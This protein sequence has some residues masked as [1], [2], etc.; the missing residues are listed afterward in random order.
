[1]TSEIIHLNQLSEEINQRKKD[2]ALLRDSKL[3]LVEEKGMTS[4]SIYYF[5]EKQKN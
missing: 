4:L 2:L 3:V 1:L 5:S